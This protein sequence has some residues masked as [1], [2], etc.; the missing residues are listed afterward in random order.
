MA[1]VKRQ[2]AESAAMK[3]LKIALG[4]RGVDFTEL[5]YKEFVGVAT[6]A[7]RKVNLRELRGFTP[8]RKVLPFP[9]KS[10]DSNVIKVNDHN[11][12]LNTHSVQV[13]RDL[14]SYTEVWRN[15]ESGEQTSDKD[16][17]RSWGRYALFVNGEAHT[18]V[19]RRPRNHTSADGNLFL[20]HFFYEKVAG[21]DESVITSVEIEQL[22]LKDFKK[23]FGDD[24]AKVFAHITK[25]IESIYYRTCQALDGQAIRMR[26]EYERFK[27]FSES[28]SNF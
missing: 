6:D 1:S 3:Q 24:Y 12:D 4:E 25:S 17:S 2:N 26:D 21:R 20:V 5:K 27:R 11:F 23:V 10:D 15:V 18:I 22:L 14:L 19:L 9:I 28:I 8:L 16:V 13:S 7:L